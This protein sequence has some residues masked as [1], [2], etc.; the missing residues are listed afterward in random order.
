MVNSRF[1]TGGGFVLVLASLLVPAGC[2]KTGPEFAEVEGTITL[3]GKPLPNAEVVFMSELADAKG[4][5]NPASSGYTDEKGRYSLWCNQA[6]T[7]GAVI[8]TYRVCVNDIAA[9][10]LPAMEYGDDPAA[11]RLHRPGPLRV[12]SRYSSSA[13]T[14]FKDVKIA[15]G[16]MSLNFDVK[17]NGR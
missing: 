7:Q 8:G 13:K 2:S 3:N 14:P 9:M 17:T 11:A 15:S 12:P 5:A 10:P 16:K 6:D 4:A 1:L